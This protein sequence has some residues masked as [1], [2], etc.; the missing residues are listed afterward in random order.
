MPVG[1]SQTV[2]TACLAVVD[3]YTWVQLHTGD[4]GAAGTANVAAGLSRVQATLS[5]STNT[6]TNTNALNW[7]NVPT[8]VDYTHFSVWT[9]SSAGTFGWSGTI[10][11]NAVQV[12]DNFT[13]P[14]GDLDGTMP[15][16]TT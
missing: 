2:V 6:I 16:A 11:A 5:V 1:L 3:D 10:T 14:A 9:A 7:T 15:V 4:P 13:I 8:A 12:G